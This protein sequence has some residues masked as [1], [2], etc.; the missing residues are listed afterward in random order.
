MTKFRIPVVSPQTA[1]ALFRTFAERCPNLQQLSIFVNPRW[2]PS[3]NESRLFSQENGIDYFARFFESAKHLRE[4]TCTTGLI[5]HN[6]AIFT[7]MSRLPN[8]ER[9]KIYSS[10]EGAPLSATLQPDVFPKLKSLSLLDFSPS[11]ALSVFNRAPMVRALTN[12]TLEC[13]PSQDRTIDLDGFYSTRF[14]PILCTHSPHITHLS[15]RPHVAIREDDESWFEITI[16]AL[17]L[18]S[19]LPLEALSCYGCRV[20]TRT[21]QNPCEVLAKTFPQ[22]KVL[23]WPDQPAT[24][25][26]LWFFASMPKLEHLAVYLDLETFA[27]AAPSDTRDGSSDRVS[28]FRVLESDYSQ[29]SEYNY[30]DACMFLTYVCAFFLRC[31]SHL[32]GF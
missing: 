2:G 12:V 21:N 32:L 30:V 14:I 8:L 9:L 25:N 19:S 5:Q 22:I 23:R 13:D 10:K 11:E 26:D 28:S 17:R 15:I 27:E 4:L 1:S 24:C 6:R 3:A 20:E 31:Q 16:E 29:A 18:L 7:G